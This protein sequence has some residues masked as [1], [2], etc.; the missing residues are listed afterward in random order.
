MS[1]NDDCV[2]PVYL[3]QLL[4]SGPVYVSQ[5][6]T[7]NCRN[8]SWRFD[9][10]EYVPYKLQCMN[11]RQC[12]HTRAPIM[13]ITILVKQKGKVISPTCGVVHCKEIVNCRRKV[14]MIQGK[15]QQYTPYRCRQIIASSQFQS[16]C[17]QTLQNIN[18]YRWILLI[19]FA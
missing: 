15:A 10:T 13:S 16:Q 14:R 2:V 12:I 11:L 18:C 7:S 5:L 1:Y 19:R 8:Y 9:S 17:M 4:R 3:S 6:E